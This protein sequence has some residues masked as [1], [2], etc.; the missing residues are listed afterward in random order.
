VAY[1]INTSY[2]YAW[3][4]FMDWGLGRPSSAGCGLREVLLYPRPAQ[5]YTAMV[6]DLAGRLIWGAKVSFFASRAPTGGVIMLHLL[7]V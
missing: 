3:D 4:I 1:A 6:A 2:C 5:Y 7:V